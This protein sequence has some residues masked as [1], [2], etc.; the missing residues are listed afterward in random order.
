MPKPPP[1][2]VKKISLLP[3]TFVPLA[4]IILSIM[5]ITPKLKDLKQRR[6]NLGLTLEDMGKELLVFPSTI[7]RWESGEREPHPQFMRAWKQFLED[8][9]RGS[10]R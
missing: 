3:L 2:F 6:I 5:D 1:F 8:R 10:M 4:S 9:E 7:S